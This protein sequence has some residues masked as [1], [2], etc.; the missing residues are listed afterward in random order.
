M[1]YYYRKNLIN[2]AEIWYNTGE[3]P[4]KKTD[5]LRYK[6][7]DQ[8]KDNAASAEDLYTILIDLSGDEDALFSKIRKNTRYEINRAN[9]RDG[10]KGI[11]FLEL[12]E[13]NKGKA[14]QYIDFYNKFADS[15]DR[16]HID[17]SD[18]EQFYNTGTFCIRCV[19]REGEA[20]FLSAHAYVVSDNTARL[21]QSSSLFRSSDDVEYR[22]LVSR[23]NRFLHWDDM[24][25]FKNGGR[26]L[27][28]DFGGWYGGEG[29]TESFKEQLL[30]NQF[31]ESFGGEKKQE[32][33]YIIPLTMKGKF[34]VCIRTIIKTSKKI[35]K[36]IHVP[37][38][39]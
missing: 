10:V 28:Y 33:S 24:V 29:T 32:Y 13:K 30:I 2:I 1:I 22:N 3:R 21:H 26:V 19:V 35:I 23:A 9:N 38:K 20:D 11:T 14:G 8:K 5:I 39:Q 31:K 37:E 16:S 34:A 17:F 12:N 36:K 4:E 7:A 15:K 27:Y 18:I 6:F 25:Y